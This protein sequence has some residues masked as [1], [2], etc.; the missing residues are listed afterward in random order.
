MPYKD[1]ERQRQAQREHYERNKANYLKRTQDYKGRIRRELA[2]YKAERGCA[3]CG[4]DIPVVLVF[5]HVDEIEKIDTISNMA[6]DARGRKMIWAEVA[7]CIVLCQNCH[8]I[9]HA[10]DDPLRIL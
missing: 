2:H 4:I 9:H 1:P 5:H 8:M 6:G 3:N 10:G 7:K